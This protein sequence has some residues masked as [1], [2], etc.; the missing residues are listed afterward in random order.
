[1]ALKD[2]TAPEQTA[3]RSRVVRSWKTE[4]SRNS[5]TARELQAMCD[6]LEVICNWRDC[7]QERLDHGTYREEAILS[8]EV[9]VFRHACSSLGASMHMRLR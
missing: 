9:R 6:E 8:A 7:L 1:M 4:H 2:E 3:A 5:Q